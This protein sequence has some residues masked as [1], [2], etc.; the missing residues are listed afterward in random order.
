MFLWLG[1]RSAAAALIQ[2][3]SWELPY[4]T[5]AALKK[6]NLKV[7]E[8]TIKLIK[9]KNSLGLTY[10]RCGI[11]NDWPMGNLLYSPENSTQYSVIT[12]VRK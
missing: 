12:Y 3:L 10:A 7:K 1:C 11:W 6:E 5:G 8:K 9:I 2:P 4:A